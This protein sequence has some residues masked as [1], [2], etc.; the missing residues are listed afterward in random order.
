MSSTKN[1]STK[2]VSKSLSY[3]NLLDEL[4]S[5]CGL[6]SVQNAEGKQIF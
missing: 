3:F 2:R 5:R 6:K 1:V 4:C